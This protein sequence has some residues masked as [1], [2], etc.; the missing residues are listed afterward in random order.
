MSTI[1][2]LFSELTKY[3]LILINKHE[4]GLKQECYTKHYKTHKLHLVTLVLICNTQVLRFEW[5]GGKSLLNK[6]SGD[7]KLT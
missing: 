5:L 1:K 6:L 7:F 4:V 3:I 2:L